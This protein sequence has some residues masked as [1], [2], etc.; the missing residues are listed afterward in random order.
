VGYSI[1]SRVN[2]RLAVAALTNDVARLQPH[3]DVHSDEQGSRRHST[4][5]E[6]VRKRACDHDNGV[7]GTDGNQGR[8]RD[9]LGDPVAKRSRA[10]CEIEDGDARDAIRCCAREGWLPPH[11][12]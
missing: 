7:N 5:R 11:R 3:G 10:L 4:V 6:R 12:R 2:S 8:V 9:P 1:D